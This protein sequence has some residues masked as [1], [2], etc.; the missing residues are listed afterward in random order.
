MKRF[1]AKYKFVL[2]LTALAPAL[3]ACAT[4]LEAYQA[5]DEPPS[6]EMVLDRVNTAARA[7]ELEDIM[8]RSMPISAASTWPRRADAQVPQGD[9]G[10]LMSIVMEDA[11][12]GP[13]SGFRP[14]PIRI[15]VMYLQTIY[16]ETWPN[17]YYERKYLDKPPSNDAITD[18]GHRVLGPNYNPV[19]NK[20]FYRFLR[21]TPDFRPKK[22][23]FE[24]KLNGKTAEFYPSIEDAVISLAD[25]ADQL[26][27]IR[28]DMMDV[29]GEKKKAVRDIADAAREIKALKDKGEKKNEAEIKE[30]E[31]EMQVHKKEYDNAALKYE[32]LLNA[33]KSELAK[34]K[35]QATA[36]NDEQRAL[37]ENIQAAVSATKS[38]QVDATTLVTI[39]MLKLPI[40]VY[41]LP[42]EIKRLINAPMAGLRIARIYLNLISLS[43][44]AS[45]IKNELVQLYK[46]A[47]A[48]DGLF[49]TR[50]KAK[51]AQKA[52]N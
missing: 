5:M 38:L 12:F 15:K 32:N 51:T 49:E 34:I 17:L 13:G 9:Q 25:N 37:A 8:L 14:S 22:E 30:L 33:W 45:I 19:F 26:Q 39:A 27:T 16:F 31:N 10:K 43:D 4:A 36:F 3:W 41:N 48:M 21:Y 47:D 1:W 28:N 20:S 46:E 23:H 29:D 6:V 50:I 42:D 7:L 40:S 35:Q 11:I 52:Q 2:L 24:G 18:Y 44:N